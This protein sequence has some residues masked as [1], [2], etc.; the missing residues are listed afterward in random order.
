MWQAAKDFSQGHFHHPFWY[1]QAYSSNAESLFAVPFIWLKVPVQV[2]VPLASSLFSAISVLFLAAIAKERNG[3]HSASAVLLLSFAFPHSF[4]QIT[5]LSRGFIQGIVFVAAGFYLL[6][7]SKH[8]FHFALGGLVIG[9]GL[10]QN[11]N[12]IFLLAAAVAFVPFN[13]SSIRPALSILF[14]FAISVAVYFFLLSIISPEQ[15]IHQNPPKTWSLDLLL[16]NLTRTDWLLQH[17]TPD[18]FGSFAGLLIICAGLLTLNY[19]NKRLWIGIGLVLI[20]FITTLGFNKMTDGTENI[21]FSPGRFFLSIPFALM[22]TMSHIK[23]IL[24]YKYSN[25]IILVLFVTA[26][27]ISAKEF[28][29]ASNPNRFGSAY[30]PLHIDSTEHVINYCKELKSL[31]SVT[32]AAF[33]ISGDHH[34][35]ETVSCGCP[36]AIEDFPLTLRP[37]FERRTWLWLKWKDATVGN[38]LYLDNW[39]SFDTLVRRRLGIEKTR[40]PNVYLIPAAHQTQ[41]KLMAELFPAEQ[42]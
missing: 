12:V 41:K 34:K 3:Y 8:L 15:I 16:Q 24:Q 1:G 42:F 18:W 39:N 26:A 5:M 22:L 17:T 29:N 11:I 23:V 32:K 38:V 13:K 7:R 33:I 20:G 19:R 27:F 40:L 37:K 30:V 4:W 35:L 6:N 21:F 28:R 2:A 25:T 31:A 36:A 10:F 9:I 14:G